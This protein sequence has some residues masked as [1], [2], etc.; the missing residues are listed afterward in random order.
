M[1]TKCA[2]GDKI[3]REKTSHKLINTMSMYAKVDAHM[4]EKESIAFAPSM[5]GKLAQLS[6]SK[7]HTSKRLHNFFRKMS[8]SSMYM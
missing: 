4:E 5:I 8:V 3:N 7:A 2:I 1:M 6:A